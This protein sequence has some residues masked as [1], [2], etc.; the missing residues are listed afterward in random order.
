MGCFTWTLANKEEIR[1]DGSDY[2][3]SCK[4]RYGGKGVIVCPDNTYIVE[5]KYEG[6]G[7]FDGKDIYDLVVDW[8]R[9]FL[10]MIF[11]KLK[12]RADK[13]K[14]PWGYH[15]PPWG[16]HL[17]DIAI[18]YQHGDNETIS[19]LLEK[20]SPLERQEWK[21]IIGIAIACEDENNDSLPY[22]IKITDSTD[23]APYPLLGIS[24]NCQ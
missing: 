20:L 15:S 12:S 14:N 11:D 9:P 16:Y 24:H 19:R 10:E 2:L 3:L 21:R 7:I 8:N 6:Y 17:R 22:P 13:D 23:V 4:L 18:A 5:N 1:K